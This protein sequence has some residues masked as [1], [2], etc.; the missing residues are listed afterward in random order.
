MKIIFDEWDLE[1]SKELVERLRFEWPEERIKDLARVILEKRYRFYVAKKSEL[2][3]LNA[4]E[5]RKGISY[6]ARLPHTRKI[7]ALERLTEK[8]VK[9]GK[10][11]K[12]FQVVF[13]AH[14]LRL[15][16][17]YGFE[18]YYEVFCI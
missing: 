18:F 5:R 7:Q 2:E 15:I 12:N 11:L 10:E 13:P 4:D 9:E 3:K 14:D 17:K 6:Q 16:E 8:T 1:P